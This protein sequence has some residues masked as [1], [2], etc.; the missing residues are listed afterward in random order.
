[1][2]GAGGGSAQGDLAG[3]CAVPEGGGGG[4]KGVDGGMTDV[5]VFRWI[6]V[7]FML[8]RKVPEKQEVDLGFFVVSHH[9]KQ[10]E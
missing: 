1:M 6:G 4:F 5:R 10:V 8:F 7:D 2:S 3:E 9:T